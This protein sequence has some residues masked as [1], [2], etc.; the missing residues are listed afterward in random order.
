H[1][2][3]P[4]SASSPK[5]KPPGN[6][7]MRASSS[8]AGSVASLS[9]CRSSGAAP[10]SSNARTVSA[11]QFVPPGRRTSVFTAVFVVVIVSAVEGALVGAAQVLERHV[12]EL[13]LV[14]A[15]DPQRGFGHDA[16]D[17][18]AG[19][20]LER[21]LERFTRSGLDFDEET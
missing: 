16:A 14:D 17:E 6:T 13:L 19:H 7:T 20:A 3:L 21:A 1:D 11:S 8:R 15:A 12:E 4:I 10:A 9:R 18:R 2:A 5:L